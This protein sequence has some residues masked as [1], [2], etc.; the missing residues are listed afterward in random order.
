MG[1][2]TDL[3]TKIDELVAE[4]AVDRPS[5][6]SATVAELQAIVDGLE[7]DL[8]EKLA[9]EAA[10]EKEAAELELRA[11]KA[12]KAKVEERAKRLNSEA[13]DMSGKTSEEV[14]AILSGMDP[15]PKRLFAV[16]AI[17]GAS[18][19]GM[20]RPGDEVTAAMVGGPEK[21]AAF[22]NAKF[23]QREE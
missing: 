10:A 12:A 5:T 19:Y 20:I 4:L 7:A 9:A 8:A 15:A 3:N 2:V 21:L 23:L 13:P 11:L 22:L 14:E 1:Q 17:C 18:R 16:K 6:S